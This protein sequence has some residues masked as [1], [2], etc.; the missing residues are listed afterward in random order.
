MAPQR[1]VRVDLDPPNDWESEGR[2]TLMTPTPRRID[3]IGGTDEMGCHARLEPK[4]SSSMMSLPR[5]SSSSQQ[6]R[7]HIPLVI[8]QRL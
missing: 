2:L 8:S 1:V 4:E 5:S 3:A 6:E 7:I